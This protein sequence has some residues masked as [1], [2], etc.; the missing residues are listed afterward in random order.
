MKINQKETAWIGRPIVDGRHVERLFR[1]RRRRRTPA[2][3]LV[4]NLDDQDE[5]IVWVL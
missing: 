5:R 1:R 2:P 4:A 3:N